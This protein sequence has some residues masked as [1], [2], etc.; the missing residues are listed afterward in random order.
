MARGNLK[1]T[2]NELSGGDKERGVARQIYIKP[3]VERIAKEYCKQQN[4][5]FSLMIRIALEEYLSKRGMQ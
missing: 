2:Q 4:M 1:L 3:A 5:S